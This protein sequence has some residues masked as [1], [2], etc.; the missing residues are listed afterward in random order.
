[1]IDRRQWATL[2]LVAPTLAALS[3]VA[4]AQSTGRPQSAPTATGAP[5]DLASA[6]NRAGRQ[7]ALSQRMS[8]AYVQI[9]LGIE[10][11]EAR[12]VLSASV[13]AFER[14]QQLLMNFAPSAEIRETYDTLGN[15]WQRA[16]PL[17]QASPTKQSAAQLVALDG[18]MLQTAN[19]GTLQLQQA[20]NQPGALL[21]NVA[22]RQRMLSQRIAKFQ[23]CK[24]WEVETA[25]ADQEVPRSRQ[26]FLAAMT[27]LKDQARTEPQR[28]SLRTAELQWVF[29]DAAIGTA[30]SGGSSNAQ[31]QLAAASELILAAFDDVT[32]AFERGAN[33]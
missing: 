29:F 30:W 18:Q 19:L 2:A 17:L 33:T 24:V 9:G 28:E 23:F 8:K 6:I 16:K 1:M 14:S 4:P 5:P 20:I 32:T 3:P 25:L 21:V 7:R 12:R 11:E 10:A 15:L 26:E 22:G 31:R 27:R 13:A